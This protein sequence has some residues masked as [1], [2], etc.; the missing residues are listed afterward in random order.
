[1]RVAL[2]SII[3]PREHYQLNRR[4]IQ[5]F[6]GRIGVGDVLANAS[7]AR[8]GGHFGLRLTSALLP[9]KGKRRKRI[10]NCF[11][12]LDISEHIQRRIYMGAYEPI[13]TSW[14][15]ETLKEGMTFVDVGA[16]IGYFVFIASARVGLQGKV[17]ACEP[18][19]QAFRS[20]SGAILSN[21]LQN[22]VRVINAAVGDKE[23]TLTLYRPPDS[24]GNNDASLVPYLPEMT[25]FQTNMTTLSTIAASENLDVID[26]L[27]IDVEGAE[28][29]VLKGASDLARSGRIKTIFCEFNGNLLQQ[30]GHSI[31]EL[32]S[33]FQ[34]NGYKLKQEIDA[35]NYSNR[36][37]QLA[38]TRN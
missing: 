11:L 26:V 19:Q 34:D 37:Y 12:T 31:R 5:A 15:R 1:M 35:V 8:R 10:G 30:G 17:V 4:T 25:A 27:K 24:H 13:E 23:G 7:V 28:P 22:S 36:F 3:E 2:K 6:A 14:L 38:S 32:D 29:L 18:E 21:G 16:N 20:L 9:R 33:W